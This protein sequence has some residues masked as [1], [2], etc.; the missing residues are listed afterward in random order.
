MRGVAE[1]T[2]L[3]R[4]TFFIVFFW[5][6]WS[7]HHA[8]PPPA[9]KKRAPSAPGPRSIANARQDQRLIC[10]TPLNLSTTRSFKWHVI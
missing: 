9:H 4:A 2:R 10:Y 6:P 1:A 5:N 3:S 8:I 7:P